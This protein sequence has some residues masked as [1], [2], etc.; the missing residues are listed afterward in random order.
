MFSLRVLRNAADKVILY[1]PT[2]AGFIP[3]FSLRTVEARVFLAA[4]QS[5]QVVGLACIA[6]ESYRTPG[7]IGIAYIATHLA[8]RQKGVAKSLVEGLFL[9]ARERGKHIANSFYQHDGTLWLQPLMKQAALRHP[10][11]H[12]FEHSY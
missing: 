12:L 3:Y 4:L 8:H 2:V 5:G 7:A 9:L 1:Q 11:V 10:E 6:E